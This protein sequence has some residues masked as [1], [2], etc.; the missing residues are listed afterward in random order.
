MA[1]FIFIIKK[2]KKLHQFPSFVLFSRMSNV[3]LLF[4]VVLI[5]RKKKKRGHP[6]QDPRLQTWG[7]QT[8]RSWN[9]PEVRETLDLHAECKNFR[10]PDTH[11]RRYRVYPREQRS[12][13]RTGNSIPRE[14]SRVTQLR[15]WIVDSFPLVLRSVSH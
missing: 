3:L 13:Y 5:S 12:A 1:S 14:R 6:I 11:L 9:H 2:F 7:F 8:P 15:G 10:V 4:P